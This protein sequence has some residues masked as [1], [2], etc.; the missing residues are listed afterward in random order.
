MTVSVLLLS[1]DFSIRLLSV[2]SDSLD[3]TPFDLRSSEGHGLFI[4][5]FAT[6]SAVDII[7]NIRMNYFVSSKSKCLSAAKFYYRV[8]ILTV[9]T[10]NATQSKWHELKF[11]FICCLHWLVR[12]QKKLYKLNANTFTRSRFVLWIRWTWR[13]IRTVF[14]LRRS[15]MNTGTAKEKGLHTSW[16]HRSQRPNENN[17]AAHGLALTLIGEKNNIECLVCVVVK[18]FVRNYQIIRRG[19]TKYCACLWILYKSKR[20][21]VCAPCSVSALLFVATVTATVDVVVVAAATITFYVHCIH[22]IFGIRSMYHASTQL[23]CDAVGSE[24]KTNQQIKTE[25]RVFARIEWH[26]LHCDCMSSV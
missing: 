20:A 4:W 18:R 25:I 15:T 5:N 1:M 16:T 24:I 12:T 9:I 26:I 17:F 3:A 6:L 11:H 21:N 22:S 10:T 13:K 23:E 2:R 7:R 14:R 8:Q 19:D